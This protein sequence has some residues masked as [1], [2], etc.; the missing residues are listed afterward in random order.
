MTF[1][2]GWTP[3]AEDKPRSYEL[4]SA[5]ACQSCGLVLPPVEEFV[6]DHYNA[7]KMPCACGGVLRR[8]TLRLEREAP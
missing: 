4:F 1:I 6:G 2:S 3:G 7:D 5:F 8:S